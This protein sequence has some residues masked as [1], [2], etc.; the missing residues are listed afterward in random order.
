MRLNN[1]NESRVF[2]L[3][4]DV[5]REFE[6]ISRDLT[7]EN[8]IRL[9]LPDGRYATVVL[10]PRDLEPGDQGAGWFVEDGKLYLKVFSNDRDKIYQYILHE[11]VHY[12]DPSI[13]YAGT[14]GGHGKDY[15]AHPVEFNAYSNQ[16]IHV[17]IRKLAELR[18]MSDEHAEMF[19]NQL[20]DA[21]KWPREFGRWDLLPTGDIPDL[22]DWWADNPELWK[23]FKTRLYNAIQ[24]ELQINRS[25][26]DISFDDYA[27]ELLGDWEE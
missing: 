21:L 24:D 9:D 1:L 26:E 17:L 22:I 23:R 27:S 6:R 12:I 5:L 4:P 16:I 7:P 2:N 10:E 15:W 11:Y 18:S 19:L 25:E 8:P 20:Y 13:N 3:P 14:P